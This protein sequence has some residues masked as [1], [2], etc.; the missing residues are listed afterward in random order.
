M[1]GGGGGGGSHIVDLPDAISAANG[2]SGAV[3]IGNV[4]DVNDVSYLAMALHCIN[5]PESGTTT[6]T[7]QESPN[8]A[9]DDLPAHWFN[10]VAFAALDSTDGDTWYKK[11]VPDGTI[12][13]FFNKL[14]IVAVNSEA[15]Q[16]CKFAVTI[17]GY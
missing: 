7:I 12:Y 13:T 9:R 15:G 11:Q 14:R 5:G 2:G 8:Y 6:I 1:A 17:D 10:L 3:Q 16:K 4:M